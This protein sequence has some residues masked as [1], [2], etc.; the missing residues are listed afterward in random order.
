MKESV[1]IAKAV[2]T[3]KDISP[4][5][6]G[7]S[8]HRVQHEPDRQLGSLRGVI[9][10]IRHDGGMPSLDSIATELSSMHTA[11]RASVL[12]A[13]QRTHG[14]RYVQR[15]VAGI[16]AKLKIG[17]PG[18]IYEQEA[19]RVADEVMRMPDA[20]CPK[21]K[22]ENNVLIKTKPLAEQITPLVQGQVEPEKEEKEEEEILQL[23]EVSGQTPEVTPDFESRIQSL[24]SS[25]QPLP[26][27]DRSFMERGFGVD[28]SGVRVHTDSEADQLNKE[29]NAQAFTYGRDIY[30]GAGKYSPGTLAGKRLLAH[31]LTHVVQKAQMGRTTLQRA[32]VDDNPETPTPT[33]VPPISRGIYRI[34]EP[35]TGWAPVRPIYFIIRRGEPFELPHFCKVS[36]TTPGSSQSRIEIIE[37]R[38]GGKDADIDNRYLISDPGA[39][40]AASVIFDISSGNLGYGTS[41]PVSAI[42]DPSNPTPTGTHDL[43]IPDFSHSLGSA[44]GTY[45]TT[46]F[47]VGHSGDR[48]LH[49]GRSSAGCV[50]V[51]DIDQWTSIYTYLIRARLDNRS[52]GR[53]TVR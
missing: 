7:N 9:N 40:P 48:Y 53:I 16:Q 23:K 12:L 34:D 21:C 6:S 25:G 14:N 19:D 37:A 52:V 42:T 32:E 4:T 49:P 20:A 36:V 43:E 35:T 13:L 51:T 30:F 17:Q 38:Y 33:P 11:Q 47:R 44:Y 10:N 45:G 22:E 8:I 15:V 41:G 3:K 26:E 2:D 29:L 31:E 27:A 5:R 46:W 28:F 50:T 24:K 18:D 39:E 1:A